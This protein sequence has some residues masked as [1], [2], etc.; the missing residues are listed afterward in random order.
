VYLT[1]IEGQDAQIHQPQRN[2]ASIA[3]GAAV[4]QVSSQAICAPAK[5][6]RCIKRL[7]GC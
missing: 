3:R 5:R 7:P 4:G 2:R 1:T 6:P